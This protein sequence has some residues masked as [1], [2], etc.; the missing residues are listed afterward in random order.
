[1]KIFRAG[2]VVLCMLFVTPAASGMTSLDDGALA[3]CSAGSGVSIGISSTALINVGSHWYQDA[4]YDILSPGY[5]NRIEF[6]NIAR[7]LSVVTPPG[8][9]I[10]I[11]IGTYAGRTYVNLQNP[12]R[13]SSSFSANLHFDEYYPGATNL[14]NYDQYYY[15]PVLNI[16]DHM[17]DYIVHELGTIDVSNM[18]RTESSLLIGAHANS[19]VDFYQQA[20]TDIDFAQFAYN[21]PVST[22]ALT[23]T[24]IHLAGLASGDPKYPSGHTNTGPGDPDPTTPPWGFSGPFKIGTIADGPAQIDIGTSVSS[25]ATMMQYNL[26]MEGSIRVEDVMFGTNVPGTPGDFGPLALDGIEVHHLTIQFHP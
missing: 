15:D 10:T 5:K 6:E 4:D 20:K 25:G 12:A 21:T 2:L 11:D 18:V 8:D 22:N 17:T 24:G 26:P 1:M 23:F 9:P 13:V 3:A 16:Y 14:Q 7:S 19:G